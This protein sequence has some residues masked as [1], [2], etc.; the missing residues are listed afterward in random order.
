MASTDLDQFIQTLAS[1]LSISTSQNSTRENPVTENKLRLSPLQ[2]A[3]I[4]D[5]VEKCERLVSEGED[6]HAKCQVSGA[7]LLHFAAVNLING[8]ELIEFFA[9]RGLKVNAKDKN[10][11]EPIHYAIRAKNFAVANEL[12]KR[13]PGEE[14]SKNNN[15]LHFCVSEN[16]LELAKLALESDK[17]TLFAYG[18]LGRNVIHLAAGYADAEMCVW[19]LGA[20]AD[21]RA[22]SKDGYADSALHYAA[23]NTGHGQEIVAYFVSTLGHDVNAKDDLRF[24]PLFYALGV[25][26]LA[27]AEILISLGADLKCK[28]ENGENVM[29]YCIRRNRQKS[30]KFV[31]AKEPQLVK[32]AKAD[33][34]SCLH[35]AAQH[36][37]LN[38]CNWL[39]HECGVD[40]LAWCTRRQKSVLHYAAGNTR[41][42]K[43]II[44]CF[45][46][47][48]AL[49]LNG[50]DKNGWTPLRHAF[51]AE[52]VDAAE[53]LLTLGADSKVKRGADNLNPFCVRLS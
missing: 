50:R 8:P 46:A 23:L 35:L 31:H 32:Q 6:L 20:G 45:V 37:D 43:D 30:A 52:N 10:G 13:R 16:D 38:L 36:A 47:K 19:L 29:H 4:F 21:A 39:V 26:N 33:G 34:R 9:S 42:G 53:E 22:L 40:A 41:H 25:E 44:S 2:M 7:T 3:A 1:L 11:K 27:A 18:E 24:T 15:L 48:F 14:K 51:H 49:H 12:L 5:E 17:E 28:L